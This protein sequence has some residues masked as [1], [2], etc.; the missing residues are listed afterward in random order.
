[1]D[2]GL[3][4]IVTLECRDVCRDGFGLKDAVDAGASWYHLPL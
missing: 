1:M 2:H 4:D 3:S